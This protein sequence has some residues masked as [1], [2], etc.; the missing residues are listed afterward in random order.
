MP[1]S[2]AVSV[3]EIVTVDV[4]RSMTS[5]TALEAPV[6]GEMH[7]KTCGE[8]FPLGDRV[9]AVEVVE[10]HQRQDGSLCGS[11]DVEFAGTW[12]VTRRER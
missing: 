3:D 7:C 10:H 9:G 5:P 6:I 2:T 4:P 11:T 12:V 1:S 8:N